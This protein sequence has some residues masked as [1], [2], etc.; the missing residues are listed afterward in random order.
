MFRLANRSR[1]F[2]AML[3]VA[4][5]ALR[6]A[7]LHVHMCMDGSEAPLD[8]HVAD[9]GVHH[10]DEP[11][12][13]H[14]DLEMAIAPDAVLKKPF[15]DFA[16]TLLAA[17]GAL[18]LFVLARPRERFSFPPVPVRAA[19]ARTHLRPPLRGPPRFA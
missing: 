12:T 9:T 19:S 5:V 17:F 6:V 8:I 1:P 4:M 13:G 2:I 3:C 16:L 11:D 14:E 18:L 7:G 10:H 15:G